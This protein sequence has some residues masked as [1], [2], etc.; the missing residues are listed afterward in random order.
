MGDDVSFPVAHVALCT[1]LKHTLGQN[2]LV[3]YCGSLV[4]DKLVNWMSH[5]YRVEVVHRFP[6]SSRLFQTTDSESDKS[7]SSL[8]QLGRIG[9]N[10]LETKTIVQ[11][12][13]GF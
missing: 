3:L 12:Y 10:T 2:L 7:H 5:Y 8:C 9:V 4:L 11:A 6:D 13:Q 1:A